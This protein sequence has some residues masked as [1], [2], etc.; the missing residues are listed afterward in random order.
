MRVSEKIILPSHEFEK[1]ISFLCLILQLIF[2]FKI[3][4]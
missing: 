3:F 4:V 1:S 2:L